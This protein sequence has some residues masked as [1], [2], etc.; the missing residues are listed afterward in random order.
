MGG[1]DYFIDDKNTITGSIMYNFGD[2][3]N[4][5]KLTYNDFINGEASGTTIR[6]DREQED[7]K[8]IEG[9]LS[10]KREFNRKD[11]TLTVDFQYNERLDGE[12]SGFTQTEDESTILQRAENIAEDGNSKRE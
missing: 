2:G 12:T 3:L 8:N 9:A 1:I 6:T 11:Q 4:T 7:E 5:S 10:Y